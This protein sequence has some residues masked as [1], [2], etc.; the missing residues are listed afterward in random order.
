MEEGE[1]ENMCG[2]GGEGEHVWRRGRGRTCVEE[3]ER[4]NMC[5]GGGEGEHVWRRRGEGEHVWRRG[6]GRT[7]VEEREREN[8]CGGGGEGEHVW[9]G[10]R[11]SICAE[12]DEYVRGSITLNSEHLIP[13]GI[14]THSFLLQSISDTHVR[15]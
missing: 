11:E 12:S 1:R 15:R 7:C 13:L 8:M 6:I 4:E 10:E 14:N 9:R 3:G 2:G 5:G